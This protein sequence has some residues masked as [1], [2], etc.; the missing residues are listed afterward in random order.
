M[1]K[2]A[3]THPAPTRSA[4]TGRGRIFRTSRRLR[5]SEVPCFATGSGSSAPSSARSSRISPRTSSKA[6]ATPAPSHTLALKFNSE[7]ADVPHA[8][9]SSFFTPEAGY[10]QTQDL[11]IYN[12]SYDAVLN[13]NWLANF[14]VGYLENK[15][16]ARPHSGDLDTTGTIDQVT[17][18][19]SGNYTNVQTSERPRLQALASTSYIAEF[20]GSHVF[21][22]G[23]DLE[24]TKFSSVNNVTGTPLDPSFCSE[25]FGQPAGATCGAINEPADGANFLYLVYTDVAE[26]T[27]EGRGMSFYAQD[28]WRPVQ[29]VTAKIGLRYDEA[30]FYLP[31]DEKVKTFA[32][33]QPRVGVA[34]DLF[35]DSTTILYGADRSSG[36]DSSARSAGL[37]ATRSTRPCGRP[38]PSR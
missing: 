1:R 17:G 5:P 9:N 31:G 37:R 7:T 3:T 32:R 15:L 21:K 28:E 23:T 19:A 24:W 18:I 12:A 2:P 25:Q 16:D 14:Q 35:N 38:T 8:Q 26:Q 6:T 34:W 10:D 29:N 22:V 4:T 11:R 36:I 30:D 27:F 33:F 20:L 13:P